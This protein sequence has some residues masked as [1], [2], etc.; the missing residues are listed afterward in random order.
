[1]TDSQEENTKL[2]LL[3]KNQELREI[4][5]AQ[6]EDIKYLRATLD[7]LETTLMKAN[8]DKVRAE[9]NHFEALA[10]IDACMKSFQNINIRTTIVDGDKLFGKFGFFW[11]KNKLYEEAFISIHDTCSDIKKHFKEIYD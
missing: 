3:K 9:K 2:F 8:L 10:F 6:D 11:K 7:N 5:H 4:L 1:M